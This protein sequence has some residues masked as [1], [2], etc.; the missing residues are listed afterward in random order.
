MVYRRRARIARIGHNQLAGSDAMNGRHGA[1][2]A[3]RKAFSDPS[4]YNPDCLDLNL[5][6]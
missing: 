2:K 3:Q 6:R 5:F 4:E 1:L